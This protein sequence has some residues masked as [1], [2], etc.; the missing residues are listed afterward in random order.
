MTNPIQFNVS[1]TAAK[2]VPNQQSV[3]NSQEQATRS[4]SPTQISHASQTAA[5]RDTTRLDRSSSKR[6]VQTPSRVESKG[7]A[8]AGKRVPDRLASE[9]E[10]EKSPVN[11]DERLDLSA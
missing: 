7:E 6:A 9:E 5:A 8:L 2:V 11:L 4:A 1:V 3:S 10:K